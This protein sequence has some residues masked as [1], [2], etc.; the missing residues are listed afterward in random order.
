MDVIIQLSVC[1]Y[2]CADVG[3]N[4]QRRPGEAPVDQNRFVAVGRGCNSGEIEEKAN[5]IVI[6]HRTQDRQDSDSHEPIE[7]H[8]EKNTLGRLGKVD[9]LHVMG[10]FMFVDLSR[11]EEPM[12]F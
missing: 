12:D 5:Q 11:D 7:L 3:G 9:L 4:R 6:L 8:V 10:Q 2:N 1:Y